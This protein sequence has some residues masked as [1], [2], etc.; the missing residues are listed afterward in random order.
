MSRLTA[1]EMYLIMRGHQRFMPDPQT[2]FTVPTTELAV[3]QRTQ[4]GLTC[5]AWPSP[6]GKRSPS[7]TSST[8]IPGTQRPFSSAPRMAAAPVQSAATFGSNALKPPIGVRAEPNDHH[9]L[10]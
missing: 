2:L 4:R 6:A 9:R 3:N 5:G 1:R 7:K 8:R 10:N